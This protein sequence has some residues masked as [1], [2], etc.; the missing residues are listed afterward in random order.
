MENYVLQVNNE[1]HLPVFKEYEFE[2]DS[3]KRYKHSLKACSKLLEDW[4]KVIISA[5]GSWVTQ[6][7]NIAEDLKSSFSDIDQTIEIFNTVHKKIWVPKSDECLD[8]IEV[9]RNVPSIR[10]FLTKQECKMPIVIENQL[11]ADAKSLLQKAAKEL[12]SKRKNFSPRK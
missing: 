5:Q 4:K 3:H 7:V 8:S 10:I 1:K 11:N 6:A 12:Y 2:I 9:T